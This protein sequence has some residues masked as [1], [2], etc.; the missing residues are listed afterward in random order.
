MKMIIGLWQWPIIN[1]PSLQDLT[2]DVHLMVHPSLSNLELSDMPM[3]TLE[4]QK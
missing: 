3:I 2:L 1:I 4:M